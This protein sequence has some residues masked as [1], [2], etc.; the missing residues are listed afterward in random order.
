MDIQ[1]VHTYAAFIRVFEMGFCCPGLSSSKELHFWGLWQSFCYVFLFYFYFFAT[2]FIKYIMFARLIIISKPWFYR[3]ESGYEWWRSSLIGCIVGF[4]A[5]SLLCFRSMLKLPDFW[6]WWRLLL[7]II[8]HTLSLN[9]T[10]S[11]GMPRSKTYLHVPPHY[12][13]TFSIFLEGI[14]PKI[15]IRINMWIANGL[16]LVKKFLLA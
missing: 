5:G 16:L 13:I 6:I 4:A 1:E 3:Q 15:K 9:P 14:I 8:Q 12:C 10:L 7:L 2:W 11:G